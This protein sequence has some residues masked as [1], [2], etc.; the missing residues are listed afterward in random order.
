MTCLESFL[1]EKY[2]GYEDRRHKKPYMGHPIKV[3][4]NN[5]GYYNPQHCTVCVTFPGPD[6]H[7]FELTLYPLP[8]SVQVKEFLA[9]NSIAFPPGE[10]AGEVTLHLELAESPRIYDLAYALLR[11]LEG[12]PEY[13]NRH[14]R[15]I[16]A[17]TA[18]A[19]KQLASHLDEFKK[20]PPS[21]PDP[22]PPQAKAKRGRK[23]K[24][25]ASPTADP[26]QD[27]FVLLERS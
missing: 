1:C 3:D 14:W 7:Q 20:L 10:S 22:V 11:T 12:T 6:P 18:K 27:L 17:R 19:L 5:N 16:C 4:D 15:W 9:D 2:G 26:E 23:K 21:A 24:Y 25:A 13:T 8:L